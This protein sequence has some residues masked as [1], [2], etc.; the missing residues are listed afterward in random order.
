[1][2]K[3]EAEIFGKYVSINRKINKWTIEGLA[4]ASNFSYS[5]VRNIEQGTSNINQESKNRI[6][7]LFGYERFMDN[8]GQIKLYKKILHHI[9]YLH[10][11]AQIKEM[12]EYIKKIL[13]KEELKSSFL[14]FQYYL[15][16][17][18]YL[19]YTGE[20][21]NQRNQLKKI[22]KENLNFFSNDEVAIFY[23][24]LYIDSSQNDGNENTTHFLLKAY[25]CNPN[26]FLINLHLAMNLQR[27]QYLVSSLNYLENCKRLLYS[28]NSIYRFM[29]IGLLEASVMMD[30][31]DRASAIHYFFHLL[32]EAERYHVDSIK[33]SILNNIAYTCFV[34]ED[35]I[36]TLKYSLFALENENNVK[37]DVYFYIV[38]SHYK[39]KN[40]SAY[41]QS[42]LL[43]KKILSGTSYLY[44]LLLGIDSLFNDDIDQAIENFKIA[45]INTEKRMI[46]DWSVWIWKYLCSLYQQTKNFDRFL[47]YQK[48]IEEIHQ[49]RTSMSY[50]PKE[51]KE[52]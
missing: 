35:Y 46:L 41:Q 7:N 43:A 18:Y 25:D 49:R 10:S 39:L 19:V 15:L 31:G 23:D 9:V 51:N 32:N 21:N 13:K 50:F 12:L 30:N 28:C 40:T 2:N 44:D 26:S 11:T 37:L 27:N 20:E 29:Q 16:Q 47:F 42:F 1:M 38:F 17:F 6:A 3:R 5:T 45:A 36:N 52:I 8:I 48:K 33:S 14:F 4:K 22:L 34:D 24:L